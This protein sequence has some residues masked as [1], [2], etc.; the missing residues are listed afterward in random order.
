[1]TIPH[2]DV[3]KEELL[4]FLF[5]EPGYSALAADA[6]QEL[7]VL[8]PELTER[9]LHDRYRNAVSHWAN[10]VQFARE[11]LAEEGLVYRPGSN[12]QAP[13]GRWMLTPRGVRRARELLDQA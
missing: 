6:Y 1:M 9:E 13:R 2:E 8:H 11:R 10:S 7:A 5:R 12:P 4:L 3:L